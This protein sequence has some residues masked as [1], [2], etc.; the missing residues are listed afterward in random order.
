MD[1]VSQMILKKL[2]F[3]KRLLKKLFHRHV[4]VTPE[5]FA[6]FTYSRSNHF[7]T[8]RRPESQAD[9]SPDDCVLKVYQD[10][11]VYNFILDNFSEGAKLLEVGGGDSRII[12]WLKYHYEF[13]NLDKLEGV[14]NGLTSL[15]DTGGFRLIQGYIGDFSA[16]LPSS[17]FDGIF[18][19]SV[20]EHV[21]RDNTTM[22]AM[23]E[24][25]L[26][27]LKP[28]GL[29]MHCID[30][31]V[32]KDVVRKHPLVEYMSAN[33]PCANL[34]VSDAVMSH[35]PELWGMSKIAYDRNWLGVINVD[36]ET[37]GVPVSYNCIWRK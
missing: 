4:P 2:F 24:D 22:Q 25:M 6:Q 11:L 36:Y 19:I 17:Y 15:D 5:N 28:G 3:G 30:I 13:W 27:L 1:E 32:K 33:M 12:S 16:E 31:V 37:F 35:D 21:P 26:R 10:M 9:C 8:L 29:S 20:L 7:Q 18:S 34:L 23:C 14:G